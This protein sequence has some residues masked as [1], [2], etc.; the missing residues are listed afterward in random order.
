MDE[1]IERQ[2]L[3]NKLKER[4]LC[5]CVTEWDIKDA[6]AA[7][8]APVRHGRWECIYD[9]ST[10]ETDITCSYCK[11]TRTIKGCFVSTDGKSCYFEDDYCPNCGARMDGDNNGER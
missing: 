7:D 2:A 1:Y 6:P 11:N 9:D 4:D 3:L 8:V 5:L 10:G